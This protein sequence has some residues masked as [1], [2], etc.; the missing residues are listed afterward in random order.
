MNLN[1]RLTDYVFSKGLN[2][3]TESL[4]R[5]EGFSSKAYTCP[6]GKITVGYGRN[7]EDL[8]ITKDEAETLLHNDIIRIWREAHQAFPW[9]EKL[10]EARESAILNMIFQLG[11]SRFSRFKK[12]IVFL[13]KE[14]YEKA[15]DEALN[16]AW[17]K[18]TPKR[19]KEVAEI[20]R[21]GFM[22]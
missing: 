7:L 12:M 1:E 22:V 2:H 5:H 13:E 9:F 20:I 14:E 8:G 11:I 19:A 15:A 10:D 17:A 6:A 16:S 21:D 3:L 18:Q 4:K